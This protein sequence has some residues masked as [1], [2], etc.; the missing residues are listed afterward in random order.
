MSNYL[1]LAMADLVSPQ[2][3][4]GVLSGHL[5]SLFSFA[6]TEGGKNVNVHTSLTISA[7]Y[8]AVNTIANS[9]ALLPMSPYKESNGTREPF[10]DHSAY[11]LLYRE[12]NSYMTAFQFKFIMAVAV[13]MKGNAYALIQR[14]NSGFPMAYQF[15][16]PEDVQ[17]IES[18]DKLFY[19]HKGVIYAAADIVHIPG[20][21]F[22]GVTGQSV[23]THAADNLGVSLTA[24]KFG[25]DSLQDRGISQAVVETDKQ[26]NPRGKEAFANSFSTALATGNKH[27]VAVLDEGFKYKKITLSPAESQFIETYASGIEDIARWFQIPAHKLHIK[28]EGG[29]NFLVQMSIEYLQT[30]VMPLAEKF[31]QEF[32]RKTFTFSERKAGAY[33]YLNYKKL[34]QAD[35]KSRAQ[36]YK[37]M[38]FM[39]AFNAN[40]I[41]ALEDENPR[42]DEGGEHYMQLSNL[43]NEDQLQELI[44]ESIKS[45]SNE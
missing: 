45:Q 35:P 11:Y 38:Y 6:R 28:G 15:L 8:C 40:E 29:Y 10:K 27:R 19:R 33:I 31:K 20:F 43:L 2:K 24:Q 26:V 21:S 16:H 3:R 30:A 14:D 23:I 36:Y 32:E 37:D 17:V 42:T 13:M 9:M 12:P 7:F 39:G 4:S 34:L 41:R 44:K 5:S 18:N 25:S 22:D 1:S